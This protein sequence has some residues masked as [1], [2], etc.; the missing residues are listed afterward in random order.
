MNTLVKVTCQGH[1][2]DYLETNTIKTR[3][4]SSGCM[5]ALVKRFCID[6]PPDETQ[7]LPQLTWKRQILQCLFLKH[8]KHLFILHFVIL[9]VLCSASQ[10][11]ERTLTQL[12]IAFPTE[13]GIS[14]SGLV[15]R[16]MSHKN[17][18][19]VIRRRYFTEC[20]EFSFTWWGLMHYKNDK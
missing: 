3:L 18:N 16:K 11:R 4:K 15:L 20:R 17:E 6:L 9:I 8:Q 10:C 14:T 19:S 12:K 13:I 2:S 5:S 7:I 1:V